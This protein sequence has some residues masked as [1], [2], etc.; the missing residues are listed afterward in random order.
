MTAHFYN[1]RI[2]SGAILEAWRNSVKT[3]FGLSRC[4][5]KT[6]RNQATATQ[7][8]SLSLRHKSLNNGAQFFRARFGRFYGFVHDEGTGKTTQKRATLIALSTEFSCFLMVP[9]GLFERN[10]V[11][12]KGAFNFL[13]GFCTESVNLKQVILALAGESPD[14]AD[15]RSRE[16]SLNAR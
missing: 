4:A 14:R 16:R 10:A 2:A 15:I 12:R 7:G 13:N 3:F 5:A 11:G 8:V 9:H 1:A 6:S